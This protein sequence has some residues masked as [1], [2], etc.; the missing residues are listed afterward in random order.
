MYQICDMHSHILPAMDD[1]CKTATE[2]VAVLKQAWAQGIQRLI[3]TPH[4]YYKAETPGAFLARRDVSE[5]QLRRAL[6]VEKVRMPQFCCGAEVAYFQGMDRCEELQQ[7]CLGN[8]RYLLLELPREPWNS[9]LLREVQNLTVQGFVPVLAHFERY[10]PI[11]S[12]QSLQRL[13]E[14]EPLVQ[15][16]AESLMGF[17]CGGKHR[18]MLAR[19]QVHLLGSDCHGLSYRPYVLGQALARLE[20][21]GMAQ[22]LASVEELSNAIF[23]QAV[24]EKQE[25]GE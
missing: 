7:L 22:A 6:A 4:Y 16:N 13:L 9:Q 19:G 21:Q 12:R 8:S 18:K 11:Q 24:N 1:G 15:M 10:I 17:F 2:A 5:A 20:K 23:Q 3:A 25:T 14:L